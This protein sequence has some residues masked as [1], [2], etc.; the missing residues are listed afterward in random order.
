MIEAVKKITKKLD[1]E[2]DEKEY[3]ETEV[4][5]YYFS[6]DISYDKFMNKVYAVNDNTPDSIMCWPKWEDNGDRYIFTTQTSEQFKN[7][8]IP[9]PLGSNKL[10]TPDSSEIDV[11]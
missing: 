10:Q 5:C 7:K 8:E 2:P 3:K 6:V 9:D 4:K 11:L 1:K